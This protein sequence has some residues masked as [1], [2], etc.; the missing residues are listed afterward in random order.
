MA[1]TNWTVNDIVKPEDMNQIGLEINKNAVDIGGMSSVHG[2]HLNDSVSHV[3]YAPDTGTANAKVIA[4]NPAPT[5]YVEG[6]AIAFKNKTQNTGTVTININDLGAKSVLKSNGNA[7]TSGNLKANSIYTL[8]YN[9]TNFILQGEGGAEGNI[10]P[11]KALVGATYTDPTTGNLTNGT[12]PNRGAPT[13]QPGTPIQPGYYSGG[14]AGYPYHNVEIYNTPGSYSF[15]VPAN[16]DQLFILAVGGGGGGGGYGS[17]FNIYGGG[18]GG[19]GIAIFTMSVVPGANVPI[20]VGGG[21]TAGVTDTDYG[22][23][24]SGGV[25]GNSSVSSIVAAGGHGGDGGGGGVAH[26]GQGGDGGGEFGSRGGHGGY[27]NGSGSGAGGGSLGEGAGA[28]GSGGAKGQ[29][30]KVLIFY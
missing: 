21:G 12:M 16:V 7:L 29:N 24:F 19:G 1:K 17:R 25:G 9:G 23:G 14:K 10:T 11:D 27:G 30:G 28:G 18:G 4:L 2:E 22:Y 8:R 3:H 20:L 26:G 6:M 13:L 5:A 15:I